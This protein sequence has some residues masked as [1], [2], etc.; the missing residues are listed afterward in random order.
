MAV[1]LFVYII[2]LVVSLGQRPIAESIFTLIGSFIPLTVNGLVLFGQI[3]TQNVVP[4]FKRS[5]LPV[6]N[7]DNAIDCVDTELCLCRVFNL[8][9]EGNF[10]ISSLLDGVR[11]RFKDQTTLCG[12]LIQHIIDLNVTVWTDVPYSN[13]YDLS[14]CIGKRMHGEY[15]SRHTKYS[16]PADIF[17]NI[18]AVYKWLATSF[19][20]TK[21]TVKE[22]RKEIVDRFKKNFFISR[23]HF[24]RLI[25]SR[26]NRLQKYYREVH[27]MTIGVWPLAQIELFHYK[28]LTGYYHYL[29]D[30]M[31]WSNAKIALGTPSENLEILTAEYHQFSE[32]MKTVTTST[33][34]RVKDMINTDIISKMPTWPKFSGPM[35]NNLKEQF[36]F[37]SVRVNWPTLEDFSVW[38]KST[39]PPK[40]AVIVGKRILANAAHAIWP[41]STSKEHHEKFIVGGNCRIVDGVIFEGSKIVDYCLRDAARNIPELNEYVGSYLNMTSHMRSTLL[42]HGTINYTTTGSGKWKRPKVVY[43]ETTRKTSRVHRDIYHRA[44]AHRFDPTFAVFNL[45]G[46]DIIQTIDIYYRDFKLWMNNKNMEDSDRPDVG[47]KYWINHMTI[48]K[49]PSSLDCSY[50][51]GLWEALKQVGLIYLIVFAILAV[52]F[53]PMLSLLS[54]IF[55]FLTFLLIV[56]IVAFNYSPA[57]VALFPTST[58]GSTIYTIP[59]LPIPLNIFPAIPM[60]L[61]D[62]LFEIV[63]KIFATCYDWIP[64]SVLNNEQCGAPVSF[65][66]CATVGILS[67]LQVTIYW[68]HKLFGSIACDVL[69]PLTSLIPYFGYAGTTCHAIDT[70]SPTQM[71]RQLM[72]A[73]LNI[74]LLAWVLLFAFVIATFITTVVLAVIGILHAFILLI[75]MLPFYNALVGMGTAQGVFLIQNEDEGPE[76]G[77]EEDKEDK[78][79]ERRISAKFTP[80]RVGIIDKIANLFITKEKQEKLE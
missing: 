48:C 76:E 30:E 29:Y 40:P 65:P 20:V 60:C 68:A 28:Y 42:H 34:A 19:G 27:Q 36:H 57:C 1:Y 47:A 75:P 17:Y 74:G 70:A 39:A 43:T 44:H 3:F 33:A 51:I 50:G 62:S 18:A 13:R 78:P 77:E 49:F 54:F 7:F 53:P 32:N 72:C 45:F 9:C 4:G 6:L 21:F 69:I 67:T 46:I 61:W 24:A 80:K 31:S 56:S 66:D 23:D 15:I 38:P 73:S 5:E 2:A 79:I 35:F 26:G 58:L 52:I 64:Q 14:D 71:D 55:N 59:I 25:N 8:D 10:T 22:E 16:V 11:T 41:Y 12:S 37:P 63:D